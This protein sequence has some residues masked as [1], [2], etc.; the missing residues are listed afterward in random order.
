MQACVLCRRLVNIHKGAQEWCVWYDVVW[1]GVVWCGVNIAWSGVV[2]YVVVG[3]TLSWYCTAWTDA[4]VTP[5][6]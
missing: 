2:L 6:R 5:Y 4:L 1:Y 3:P